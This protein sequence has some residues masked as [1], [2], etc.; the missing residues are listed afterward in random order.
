MIKL[1]TRDGGKWW[2]KDKTFGGDQN[3][4]NIDYFL[5]KVGKC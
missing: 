5:K 1:I 2:S 4:Q 3:A